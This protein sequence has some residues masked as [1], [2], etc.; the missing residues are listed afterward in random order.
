MSI[1]LHIPCFSQ[2]IDIKNLNKSA[3]KKSVNDFGFHHIMESCEDSPCRSQIEARIFLG[4]G[5][6]GTGHRWKCLSFY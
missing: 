2:L 4:L 5:F 3:G 6:S 1:F